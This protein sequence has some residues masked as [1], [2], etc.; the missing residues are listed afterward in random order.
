ML[1]SA[2]SLAR[3]AA[4]LS[5]GFLSL[6]GVMF[7]DSEAEDRLDQAEFHDLFLGNVGLLLPHRFDELTTDIG[8]ILAR[9]IGE[10]LQ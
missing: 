4:N 7:R 9:P 5:V 2:V 3:N 6:V 1:V 8:R 10:T